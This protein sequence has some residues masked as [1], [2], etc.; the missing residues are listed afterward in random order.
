M[1]TRNLTEADID[2]VSE[3]EDFKPY[4]DEL[5]KVI[6]SINDVNTKKVIVHRIKS[7]EEFGN[8]FNFTNLRGIDPKMDE[9]LT[10]RLQNLNGLLRQKRK[11]RASEAPEGAI[12]W[13]Y[14]QAGIAHIKDYIRKNVILSTQPVNN[15]S[16][17]YET[18]EI[19]IA[20]KYIK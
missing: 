19:N 17:I 2:Y 7:F 5:V 10:K 12:S 16:T 9:A 11:H 8:N 20:N 13:E 3:F 18:Y 14:T 4:L 15:E 1:N 6:N